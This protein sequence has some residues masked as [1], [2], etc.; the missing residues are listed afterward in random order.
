M[1]M[2]ICI[3]LYVFIYIYTYVYTYICM[4]TR[5]ILSGIRGTYSAVWIGE[6]GKERMYLCVVYVYMNLFIC[7]YMYIC[8]NVSMYVHETYFIGDQKHIFRG[9]DR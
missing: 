9:V 4:Y 1:C 6:R 2:Y 8:V 3:Y 5:Y 7:I